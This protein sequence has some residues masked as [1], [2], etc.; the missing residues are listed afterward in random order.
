VTP[1]DKTTGARVVLLVPAL[2][3][4]ADLDVIAWVRVMDEKA[5]VYIHAD[6]LG[7]IAVEEHQVSCQELIASH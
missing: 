5:V 3:D 1:I 7:H 4:A 6:V 2:T